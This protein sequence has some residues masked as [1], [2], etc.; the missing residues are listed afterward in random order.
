MHATRAMFK[1]SLLSIVRE[2]T[3]R[4]VPYELEGELAALR[5]AADKAQHEAD[6]LRQALEAEKQAEVLARVEG[7]PLESLVEGVPWNWT[8]TA[9]YL[10]AIDGT[11][12]STAE[13]CPS[14]PD[15]SVAVSLRPGV[16][17]EQVD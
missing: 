14:V 3:R 1:A 4:E 5:Q 15:A 12:G 2:G 11:G 10:D 6:S 13:L 7:M 17:L 9:E 8:S 16:E